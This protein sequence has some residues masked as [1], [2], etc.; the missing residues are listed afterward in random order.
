AHPRAGGRPAGAGASARAGIEDDTRVDQ[1]AASTPSGSVR[2]IPLV[3]AYLEL[4]AAAAALHR[5]RPPAQRSALA[6]ARAHA[7][8]RTPIVR[9]HP[10]VLRARYHAPAPGR[11]GN[12][13]DEIVRHGEQLAVDVEDGVEGSHFFHAV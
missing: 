1:G 8:G 5:A 2:G 11:R 4:P 6:A 10:G 13:L 9:Q 7:I 3:P 12:D